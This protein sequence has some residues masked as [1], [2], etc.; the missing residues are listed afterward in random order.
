MINFILY[1]ANTDWI[2][3]YK[4]IISSLSLE[5][6]QYKIITIFNYNKETRQKIE[7]LMGKNIYLLAIDHPQK[8]G[9]EIAK[10]IRDQGDWMSQILLLTPHIVFMK[11]LCKL[12]FFD[13][14][15]KRKNKESKIKEAILIALRILKRHSS[16]LFM[17]HKDLY[18]IP[19]HAILYFEKDLNNDYTLIV[20][21]YKTY[22]FK[23]SIKN[24]EFDLLPFSNFFKTHQ[25]C[26]VNLNRIERIDFKNNRIYF[27][28]HSTN[29][30]SR[31]K[32]KELKEKLEKEFYW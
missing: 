18:Q 3:K 26:I 7:N 20:T 29:L 28:M 17:Y 12:Y 5:E 25:S 24:I 31:N 11:N 15:F 6:N 32:K 8:S 21:K 22:K 1:D 10:K 9:L 4:E 14:V 30:L 16:F 23:K 19:Y 27:P 13:I 2:V